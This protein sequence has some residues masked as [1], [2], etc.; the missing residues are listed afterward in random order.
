MIFILY[1]PFETLLYLKKLGNVRQSDFL[2]IEEYFNTLD[3]LTTIITNVRGL[4]QKDRERTL[5]DVFHMGLEEHT[6]LELINQVKE[7]ESINNIM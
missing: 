2:Y 7:G 6:S 5:N 1:P 4:S 3:R